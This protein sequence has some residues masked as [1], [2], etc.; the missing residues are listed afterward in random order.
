VKEIVQNILKKKKINYLDIGA[1]NSKNGSNTKLFY[2]EGSSGV[3]VEPNPIL[4]EEI[5]RNRSR[6][7]CL[8]FGVVASGKKEENFY[9]MSDL[10]VSTFSEDEVERIKK[11]PNLYVK[12]IIKVAVVGI[13]EILEKYFSAGLDFLSIDVEGLDLEILKSLDFSKYRP[14]IVC[15]ETI[16]FNSSLQHNKQYRDD[17]TNLMLQNGYNVYMN[18]R[19][20]TIFLDSIYCSK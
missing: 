20:N 8:N 11:M 16:H 10:P 5:K 12:K 15:V 14:K 9:I 19:V 6:D 13:N 7:I 2:D 3:L 4:F 1:Y 18:N 17:I